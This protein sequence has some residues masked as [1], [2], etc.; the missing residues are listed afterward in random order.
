MF[1]KLR[2]QFLKYFSRTTSGTQEAERSTDTTDDDDK[3]RTLEPGEI[4]LIRSTWRQM[5]RDIS[6]FKMNG[7]ELFIK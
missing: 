6:K 2:K 3:R 5:R 1:R 7:A 4:E